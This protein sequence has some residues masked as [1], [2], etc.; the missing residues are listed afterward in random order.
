MATDNQDQEMH[1]GEEGD[2]P[3]KARSRFKKKVLDTRGLNIDYK[4]IEV[5]E[6]FVSK[7][8]KI[9]PRRM[10]GAT[11]RIQ[12]K[13]SREVKRARMANLLPFVKR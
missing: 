1:Q 12:R 2:S 7:T 13:I 11:A 6:K 8:G 9:L 3:R 4:N 10:T 5:I